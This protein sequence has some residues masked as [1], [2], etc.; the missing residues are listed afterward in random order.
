[1]KKIKIMLLS[2][3]LIAVV[4]GA[5]AFKVS[6]FDRN[7]CTTVPWQEGSDK[8]CTFQPPVG[9][10]ITTD[11]GP[12]PLIQSTP[13]PVAGEPEVCYTLLPVG[14]E[15]CDEKKC[16]IEAKDFRTDL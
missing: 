1:M 15:D 13:N 9:N 11:C 6:K 5:L 3:A 4:G 2:L 10:I 16:P 7:Y 14:V 8:Y 12:A